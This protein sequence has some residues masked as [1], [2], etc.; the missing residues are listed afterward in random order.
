MSFVCLS[1]LLV[2]GTEGPGEN[3]RPV[4]CHW[5]TLSHTVVH[6][7][8]IEIRTHNISNDRHW[9][10]KQCKSNYHMITATTVL[11]VICNTSSVICLNLYVGMFRH[12]V[13]LRRCDCWWHLMASRISV[14]TASSFYKYTHN[15]CKWTLYNSFY[16][17]HISICEDFIVLKLCCS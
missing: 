11:N 10:Q 4:A 9:L 17:T 12:Y 14:L 13:V 15:P 16:S 2:E 1:V 5:Q 6:I 3:H 8:L 7:A